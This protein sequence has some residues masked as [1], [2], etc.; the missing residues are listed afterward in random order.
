MGINKNGMLLDHHR[1]ADDI[2]LI[3]TDLDHLQNDVRP[4]EWIIE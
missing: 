3:A 1:F 2:L 4:V